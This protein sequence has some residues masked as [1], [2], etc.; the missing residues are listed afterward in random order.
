MP[1]WLRLI[2]AV[3]CFA[4][5]ADWPAGAARTAVITVKP[6]TV[7]QMA[8]SDI[9]CTVIKQSIGN[10]VA[11]FH[12]PGGP[13]SNV[14]KGYAIAAFDRFVAVEPP[15]S[16]RPVKSVAEPPLSSYPANK[17]GS[18]HRSVVKLKIGDGAFISGTHMT[19][20]VA[21]AKGGGNAIG[22]IYLDDKGNPIAGTSTIGISNHFVTIVK[23]TGPT[24]S[25]VLWRHSVY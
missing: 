4:L 24:S 11:C 9:Y 15:G 19:V 10:A 1:R 2:L 14:R 8:G 6:S 22:V 17:G 23:V 12:D 21:A 20:A 3:T 18:G 5:A 25:K 13:S 16:T 7:L